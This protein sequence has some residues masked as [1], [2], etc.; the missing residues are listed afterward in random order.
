MIDKETRLAN[1]F[2]DATENGGAVE[3]LM[4]KMLNSAVGLLWFHD[5]IVASGSGVLV[6]YLGH[7][8]IATCSHV[9]RRPASSPNSML[10]VYYGQTD[11]AESDHTDFI[12]KISVAK[13]EKSEGDV[14]VAAILLKPNGVE[15]LRSLG[16][17]FVKLPDEAKTHLDQGAAHFVSGFPG[18][19]QKPS[20]KKEGETIVIT[21]PLPCQ[22]TEL[23]STE[24]SEGSSR[25]R[26]RRFG[27]TW[28][29]RHNSPISMAGTSGGG[30]WELR[31]EDTESDGETT[32]EWTFHN[33]QLVGLIQS[34][35]R[36]S[37]HNPYILVEKIETWMD[38]MRGLV[39]RAG[40]KARKYM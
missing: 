28:P 10:L 36:P 34:Q 1:A 31:V 22:L 17:S 5:V 7:H 15:K 37:G 12:E 29:Q 33:P 20:A 18:E 38:E 11:F 9:N 21:F 25:I 19:Y 6:E 2:K 35:S 23:L 3:W 4:A 13:D 39:G 26:F 32:G 16:K 8:F 30:V 40:P 27:K 14:D 24:S